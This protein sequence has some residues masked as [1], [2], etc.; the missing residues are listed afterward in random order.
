MLQGMQGTNSF[1]KEGL[2][3]RVWAVS[4]AGLGGLRKKAL[5]GLRVRG[6]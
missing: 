6:W 4:G 2:V 5:G 1:K 3:I